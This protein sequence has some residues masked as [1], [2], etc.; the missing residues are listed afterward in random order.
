MNFKDLLADVGAKIIAD[1]RV[2]DAAVKM[3]A[4]L[5]ETPAAQS[6]IDREID[7]FSDK[8]LERLSGLVP[9]ASASAAEAVVK[10][11]VKGMPDLDIPGVSNVYDL[12][13]DIR[14]RINDSTPASIR[15]PSLTEMLSRLSHPF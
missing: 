5:L 12:T 9:L 3:G 14:A 1:E 13:E 15:I 2:Q 11:I 7:R 6:T 10:Q 4:K 8:A